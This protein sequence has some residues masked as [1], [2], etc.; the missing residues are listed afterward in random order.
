MTLPSPETS[1]VRLSQASGLEL[2]TLF[3]D[4][5]MSTSSAN[6]SQSSVAEEAVHI[7]ETGKKINLPLQ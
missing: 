5:R 3:K 6:K 1:L 2:R 4:S 7:W